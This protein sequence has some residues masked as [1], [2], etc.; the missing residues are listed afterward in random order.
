M[1]TERYSKGGKNPGSAAK[2]QVQKL[3]SR[4]DSAEFK[5]AGKAPADRRRYENNY[6][7]PKAYKEGVGRMRGL[8]HFLL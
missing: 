5:G 3:D 1:G 4:F 6:A 8:G 7:K 2:G